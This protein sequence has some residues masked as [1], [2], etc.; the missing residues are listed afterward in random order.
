MI[1][2]CARAHIWAQNR[3][4]LNL[5]KVVVI[6]IDSG[7]FLDGEIDSRVIETIRSSCDDI[8]IDKMKIEDLNQLIKLK[9]A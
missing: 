9:V 4:L 5:S 7:A 1:Q 2:G 6:F 3:I 8:N